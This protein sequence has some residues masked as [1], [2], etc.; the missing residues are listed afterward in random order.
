MDLANWVLRTSPKF[1]TGVKHQ[2]QSTFAPN[3]HLDPSKLAKVFFS[4]C[5]CTSAIPQLFTV[6][7]PVQLKVNKHFV[8]VNYQCY[9]NFNN[10]L[11]T[12]SVD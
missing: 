8:K 5:H 2:F 6:L 7:R 9:V 4:L 12:L 1:A 11:V 10:K 3:C